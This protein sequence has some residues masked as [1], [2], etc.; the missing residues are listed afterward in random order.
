MNRMFMS[1][2]AALAYLIGRRRDLQEAM[3]GR[4]GANVEA[5]HRDLESIDR[6]IL[7]V[8]AGRVTVFPLDSEHA[9]EVVVTG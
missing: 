7:D 6:L 1:R 8:R 5:T 2:T 3:G 4:S 9:S